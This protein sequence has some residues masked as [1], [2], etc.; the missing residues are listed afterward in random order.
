MDK[1]F[2][3]TQRGM[4]LILEPDISVEKHENQALPEKGGRAGGGGHSTLRL[5][6]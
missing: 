3:G 4:S 6:S 2:G 1:I 5:A